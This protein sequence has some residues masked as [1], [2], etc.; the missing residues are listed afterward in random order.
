M[1]KPLRREKQLWHDDAQLRAL[2]AFALGEDRQTAADAV[3]DP[4]QRQLLTALWSL[5]E[6]D[7]E[8]ASAMISAIRES[9]K[10][11]GSREE[12]AEMRLWRSILEEI[13]LQCQ[14]KSWTGGDT[15]T[16]RAVLQ[17]LCTKLGVNLLEHQQ[18][19]SYRQRAEAL[20]ETLATTYPSVVKQEGLSASLQAMLEEALLQAGGARQQTNALRTSLTPAAVH[21]VMSSP[22]VVALLMRDSPRSISNLMDGLSLP[23]PKGLAALVAADMSQRPSPSEF[24]TAK[25]HERLLLADMRDLAE[26]MPQLLG[27]ERFLSQIALQLL[28]QAQTSPDAKNLSLEEYCTFLDSL[29][30]I[31][32]TAPPSAN[33][34][35]QICLRTRL[36]V[37]RKQ[38]GWADAGTLAALLRLPWSQPLWAVP[39]KGDLRT[40]QQGAGQSDGS[41]YCDAT[42]RNRFMQAISR[43]SDGIMNEVTRSE[44]DEWL[45]D[46]V[47]SPSGGA[48]HFQTGGLLSGLLAPKAE[49]LALAKGVLLSGK[50]DQEEWSAFFRAIGGDLAALSS[51]VELSFAPD[52]PTDSLPGQDIVLKVD[53]KNCQQ[54]LV[55]VF[56]INAWNYCREM[57]HE[58]EADIELEGLG[59]T[60]SFEMTFPQGSRSLHRTRVDVPL[61]QLTGQRGIFVVELMVG[62]L[63]CRALLRIGRLAAVQDITPAGH[64]FLLFWEDGTPVDGAKVCVDEQLYEQDEGRPGHVLVPFS[65]D[66]VHKSTAVLG[67]AQGAMGAVMAFK[68]LHE[69]YELTASMVMEAES[70]ASASQP[71]APLAIW[72]KLYLHGTPVPMS[73]LTEAKLEITVTDAEGTLREHTVIITAEELQHCKEELSMQVPVALPELPQAIAARLEAK[74]QLAGRRNLATGKLDVQELS[75]LSTCYTADSC[76]QRVF[77]MYL[78]RDSS[79]FVLAVRGRAGEVVIGAHVHV[80][81]SCSALLHERLQT[82]GGAHS[83]GDSEEVMQL[84]TGDDGC[85]RLGSLPH[86]TDIWATLVQLPNSPTA[87]PDSRPLFRHW[88]LPALPS[89]GLPA[90]AAAPAAVNLAARSSSPVRIPYYNAAENFPPVKVFGEV[91]NCATWPILLATAPA[92]GGEP[93]FL[94]DETAECVTAEPGYVVLINVPEGTHRLYLSHDMWTSVVATP[95]PPP[96][97]SPKLL[98]QPWGD[99]W[100]IGRCSV[101]LAAE[102][103]PLALLSLAADTQQGVRLHLDGSPDQLASARVSIALTRFLP[104][105]GALPGR[106]SPLMHHTKAG[107]TSSLV[108][109]SSHELVPGRHLSTEVQY[110]MARRARAVNAQTPA[111]TLLQ[112]PSLLMHPMRW[113]DSV[114]KAQELNHPGEKMYCRLGKGID[115]TD[116]ADWMERMACCGAGAGGGREAGPPYLAFVSPSVIFS[117]LCPDEDGWVSISAETVAAAAGGAP[118]ANAGFGFVSAAVLSAT[119][120]ALTSAMAPVE[121]GCGAEA[122]PTVARPL[123]G[124]AAD[125]SSRCVE[126]RRVVLL[127]PGGSLP[128]PNASQGPFKYEAFDALPQVWE[129]LRSLMGVEGGAG[130]EDWTAFDAVRRWHSLTRAQKLAA[131]AERRCHELHVFVALNDGALFAE[132]VRPALASKA[133]D[134]KQFMDDWLALWPVGAVTEWDGAAAERLVAIWGGP[135]AYEALTLVEKVLLASVADGCRLREDPNAPAVELRDLGARLRPSQRLLQS[136]IHR[137]QAL[138]RFR[139]ALAASGR[140]GGADET[141]DEDIAPGAP[142]PPSRG[143]RQMMEMEMEMAAPRGTRRSARRSR[144][145]SQPMSGKEVEDLSSDDD[146]Y[147]L[148]AVANDDWELLEEERN[149]DEDTEPPREGGPEEEEDDGGDWWATVLA[150]RSKHNKQRRYQNPGP[151]IQWVEGG[152]YKQGGRGASTRR[153]VLSLAPNAFWADVCVKLA[154]RLEAGHALF[155]GEALLSEHMLELLAGSCGRGVPPGD[156]PFSR[157]LLGVALMGLPAASHCRRTAAALHSGSSTS[158]LVFIQETLKIDSQAALPE[159]ISII[160]RITQPRAH[161]HDEEEKPEDGPL[162]AG[163]TYS[164]TVILSSALSTTMAVDVLI[165]IPQGSL[166]IGDGSGTASG[167]AI[168]VDL[169]PYTSR[170]LERLFYFPFAIP[171]GKTAQQYPVTAASSLGQMLASS[172]ANPPLEVLS[173]P[174]SVVPRSK[175]DSSEELDW[176]ELSQGGTD[177]EVLRFLETGNVSGDGVKL[178]HVAW[179]ARRSASFAK[180]ATALLRRRRIFCKPIWQYALLHGDDELAI[181]EMLSMEPALAEQCGPHVDTPLLQLRPQSC[182]FFHLELWPFINPRAHELPPGGGGGAAGG[183]RYS[184]LEFSSDLKEAWG[185]LLSV[186]ARQ[187]GGPTFQQTLALAYYLLLQDRLA[188][189]HVRL[190]ALPAAAE[191]QLEPALQMQRAYMEAWVGLRLPGALTEDLLAQVKRACQAYLSPGS[192]AA[193]DGRWRRLWE[194]LAWTLAELEALRAGDAAGEEDVAGG[195]CAAAAAPAAVDPVLKARQLEGWKLEVTAEGLQGTIEVRLFPMDAEVMFSTNPFAISNQ[196]EAAWRPSDDKLGKFAFVAPSAVLTV[197]PPVAPSGATVVDVHGALPSLEQAAAVMVQLAA[198]SCTYSLPL[199]ASSMRRASTSP[200][201][202][203]LPHTLP[204]ILPP[205]IGLCSGVGIEG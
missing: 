187:A 69:E 162:V 130:R 30:P 180:E 150:A 107:K 34:L 100:V 137:Q 32:A 88:S 98:Q 190:Q 131:L 63:A 133:P 61:P 154:D 27:V 26:R 75:T 87:G 56:E 35:R 41:Q 66:G 67:C 106:P 122:A 192:A 159:G 91:M 165:P 188:E 84:Q 127:E 201:T 96:A 23:T 120:G 70:V 83:N 148:E 179:R 8:R 85:I 157:A 173:R 20:G 169:P 195:G 74:V 15:A 186:I 174:P 5:Q 62:G 19:A 113:Q 49:Q 65:E 155:G 68:H 53:M 11:T 31:L 163:R 144:L 9:H 18:D 152:Y 92:D 10:A 156:S 125:A 40:V 117:D 184:A 151:T 167:G 198:G 164:Y 142:P 110:V 115:G 194:E 140:P 73:M 178:E 197:A 13:E 168:F 129:L 177:S 7:A 119:S 182:G 123:A 203:L 28:C 183:A 118:M 22:E 114:T 86:V 25:V 161:P 199:Y 24:G 103:R 51:L 185:S 47:M 143:F 43:R 33:W 17:L 14:L 176:P 116:M 59:A 97:A 60:H 38:S 108:D 105:D 145:S 189:A 39:P 132:A 149:A 181:R 71:A 81:L 55:K 196:E 172:L 111:G 175:R 204:K 126:A 158:T 136:D 90:P 141:G 6:G 138:R 139:A 36:R 134:E 50:G 121:G 48:H 16:R 104:P 128:M 1:A 160:R 93:L 79:G 57:R 135:A 29:E 205:I 54:L 200:T 78:S 166:P 191:Q 76:S 109:P 12:V 58:V 4:L 44:V 3:E 153:R 102:E 202:A 45:L 64:S 46:A 52:C 193:A 95:P 124:S 80:S 77:D 89:S 37:Q 147:L 21:A 146:E 94:S 112:S 42:P 82:L 72:A 2:E 171:E 101:S 170:K 99:T